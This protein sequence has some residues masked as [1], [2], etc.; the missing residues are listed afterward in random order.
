M[1]QRRRL[2]VVGP[3]PPPY[4]GVTV[5]TSLLLAGPEL[6]GRFRVEHVETG[7][8]RQVPSMGR[9]TAVNVAAGT[10]ASVRF[11]RRLDGERGIVYLPL[12]QSLPGLTRDT[13]MINVAASRGWRVAAHLRGSELGDIYRRQPAP[14]RAWLRRAFDRLDSVAVLGETIR[15]ALDG[16]VDPGRVAI[17][18]NGTPDPGLNGHPARVATGL[19]LSNLARRK[20][21]VEAMRAALEVVR[22][23]QSARFVFAGEPRDRG[24]TEELRRLASQ[25]SG[26]IELR[27]PPS[28][29]QKRELLGSSAFLL[30]PPVE[31][32]GQ[33]RVVLEALAAGLPVV[34]TDRGAIAETV[35]DGVAGFVLRDPEPGLLAERM[36]RLLGDDGLRESMAERAR[37]RYLE[38]FTQESADR[39]LSEWLTRVADG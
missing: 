31:P 13:L 10:A 38:H 23:H 18:P 22:S 30:F 15:G 39:A 7:N 4:H 34:T 19:Y 35:I 12:A 8:H 17:V 6:R 28:E 37:E 24:V 16:V 11:S 32:E 26:R 33:P 20:G 21:P 1:S 27:P 14:I 9:W 29:D 5:S 25:A 36:L 3:L 2:I